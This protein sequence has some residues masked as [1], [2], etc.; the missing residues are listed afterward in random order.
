MESVE[1]SLDV[2]LSLFI[3]F[4]GLISWRPGGTIDWHSD[5]NRDYLKQRH[6]ASV[7][8]L[9]DGGADFHGGN[10][11]F[12]E[13][14]SE[15]ED[16]CNDV[17]G[18]DELN[19]LVTVQPKTGCCVAYLASEEH[20]IYP[21]INEGERFTLAVWFTH[22]VQY[23]EDNKLRRIIMNLGGK[24]HLYVPLSMFSCGPD[25]T[26]LRLC[27][28]AMRGI[29]LAES[30]HDKHSLLKNL[31]HLDDTE[32][33]FRNDNSSYFHSSFRI[34]MNTAILDNLNVLS[35]E[36]CLRS[37]HMSPSW[38]SK[39]ILSSKYISGNPSEIVDHLFQWYE[40]FVSHSMRERVCCRHLSASSSSHG[41]GQQDCGWLHKDLSPRPNSSQLST[42]NAADSCIDWYESKIEERKKSIDL[43]HQNRKKWIHAGVIF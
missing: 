9:N 38:D 24:M 15:K 22:D 33:N 25:A 27:R 10:F 36:S 18:R 8:Y 5:N 35:D 17:E 39:I 43:W 16:V 37:G 4:T 3:E 12:Q 42:T 6:V 21:P 19:Q 40:T 14:S 34:A 28:L 1:R 26:D 20:R 32:E 11:Q 41:I 31:Q 13:Y 23:D 2:N 30:T 29:A 7:T